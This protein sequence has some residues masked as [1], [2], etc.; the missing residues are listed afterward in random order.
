MASVAAEPERPGLNHEQLISLAL[1]SEAILLRISS[2]F[3]SGPASYDP[4]IR[5]ARC[6]RDHHFDIE[7]DFELAIGCGGL[8]VETIEQHVR[9]FHVWQAGQRLVV[10]NIGG[11][12]TI[13]LHRPTVCP[14]P[15]CET[16]GA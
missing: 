6:H 4:D 14:V 2:Q 11:R 9:Q 16:P 3:P 12:I 5:N 7:G 10:G 8:A 13:E 15:V 1:L